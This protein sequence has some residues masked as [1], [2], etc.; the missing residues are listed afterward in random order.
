MKK[1]KK[2]LS[3]INR[4]NKDD[5]RQNG[6]SLLFTILIMAIFL[7]ISLGVSTILIQETKITR[8]TGDSVVAF[9]AADAGVEKATMN[10]NSP[11]NFQECF[12]SPY[13]DICY[14]IQVINR[15]PDCDATN[16][17]LKSTGTY[18]GTKRGIELKF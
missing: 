7:G 14:E 4:K 8:G 16:Y 13:N 9:Y 2:E 6:I 18:K 12:S 10:R 3:I 1:F 5:R 15:G 11:S 17:C